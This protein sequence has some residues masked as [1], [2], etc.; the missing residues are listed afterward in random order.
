MYL[1]IRDDK[2]KEMLVKSLLTELD[3]WSNLQSGGV[4]C[5]LRSSL[6]LESW[7]FMCP[8]PFLGNA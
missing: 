1:V 6:R 3:Q 8:T 4:T 2:I 5:G 7:Q